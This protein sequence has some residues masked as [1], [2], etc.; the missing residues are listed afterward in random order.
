MRSKIL[1]R[2]LA[3]L[4]E[5][6]QMRKVHND[7]LVRPSA[8]LVVL[9][10]CLTLCAN[11]TLAQE[12]AYV[13]CDSQANS[14]GGVSVFDA[15]GSM[16]VTHRLSCGQEVTS[17]QVSQGYTKIQVPGTQPG[18]V[19]Y[20]VQYFIR[21]PENAQDLRDQLAHLTEEVR[22]LKAQQI[23]PTQTPNR[24]SPRISLETEKVEP[25]HP[26]AEVFGSYSYARLVTD[27]VNMHGWMVSGA[28]NVNRWFGIAGELSG[29]Y[30]EGTRAYSFLGGPR[31]SVR[32][33]KAT[34]F[35]HALV[36]GTNFG[37]GI[38]GL[39]NT[40]L[41]A[42]I[43]GG[44]DIRINRWV[45]ARAIQVDYCPILASGSLVHNVRV[46]TGFVVKF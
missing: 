7:R 12:K 33:H 34:G 26:R 40:H 16:N 18:Y 13:Y 39:T 17:L 15:P 45:G 35:F 22:T 37:V 31:F 10:F 25:E 1:E 2:H 11:R 38:F 8:I 20:V 24:P 4:G 9:S 19:G 32:S 43:G 28:G 3:K 36:G 30:G 27:G 5:K 6:I 46:A 23:V 14:S 44:T 21:K 41:A 29:H 42:A